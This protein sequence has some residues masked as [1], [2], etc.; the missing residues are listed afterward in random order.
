MPSSGFFGLFKRSVP[1]ETKPTNE[2]VE[3]RGKPADA[4]LNA[5][6]ER[7]TVY[8]L[9]SKSS[10]PDE[11]IVEIVQHSGK[12]VIDTPADM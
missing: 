5:L 2:V 6:V 7:R 12:W 4:F 11:R 10:I 8:S 9:T 3:P 1:L